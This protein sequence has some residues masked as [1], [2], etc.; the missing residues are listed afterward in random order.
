VKRLLSAPRHIRRSREILVIAS[1]SPD[2]LPVLWSYVSCRKRLPFSIR[3]RG[4][5]FHFQEQS[6][7]A[8]FWQVFG[9]NL[10]GVR[11]TDKVI[12]DAGANIGAFTLF[13]LIAAPSAR[14]IAAEPAPDSCA[15]IRSLLAEHKVA[16][17]VTLH[18]AALGASHGETTIDLDA[19]SQFRM[20]GH[21]GTPVT[22]LALSEVL[23]AEVDLL[24]MDI[25]GA[26]ADVFRTLD[27][28]VLRRIRR[29]AMEY[30]P[31]V[32]VELL[33]DQFHASGFSTT[34]RD[35]GG[36]YGMLFAL[37]QSSVVAPPS[38]GC[39]ETADSRRCGGLPI[40]YVERFSC[41]AA[42]QRRIDQDLC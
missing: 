3:L 7:V 1:Y 37:K 26:E 8:T 35:D 6:D 42:L 31:N 12:V 27:A 13:S 32:Q 20:S 17:R 19:G 34:R 28:S 4:G 5:H 21:S 10:Y 30:H 23:P 38:E 15:R 39:C 29:I 25:E 22:M 9:A 18:E 36:G 14:V 40:A 11:P 33:S 41:S 24:K 2:W 16:H